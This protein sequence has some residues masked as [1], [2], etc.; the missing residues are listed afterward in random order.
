MNDR[1]RIGM[2]HKKADWSREQFL[3]HWRGTHGPLVAGAPNLLGYWQNAVVERPAVAPGVTRG[4]WDFDGFSQL[5]FADRQ[6]SDH[7]FKSGDFATKL[8]ADERHFLGGLSIVTVTQHVVVPLP[9]ASERPALLK[10]MTLIK[11]RLELSEDD[12]R[13][14]WRVHA[15]L[16]VQMPG[17]RGYRQNVVTARERTKGQAC[18]YDDLPIDGVV[19]FWFDDAA[20][21]RAAF[22]SRAGQAT[23]RHAKVFLAEMTPFVVIEHRV[24]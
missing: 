17:V 24:V 7:A 5:W 11:R 12:F 14:E 18:G 21:S 15:D 23:A 4:P 9:E 22:S 13:R 6:G 2:I 16:V 20:G 10:R 19:E 1:G 8:M 3:E